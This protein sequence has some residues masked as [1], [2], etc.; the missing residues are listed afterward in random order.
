LV[1]TL[2]GMFRTDISGRRDLVK[3]GNEGFINKVHVGAI[4]N[5]FDRKKIFIL[6]INQLI[7]E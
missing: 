7:Q 5:N 1:G 6:K 4:S 2:R 3:L